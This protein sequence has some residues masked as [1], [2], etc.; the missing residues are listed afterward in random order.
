MGDSGPS[1][2]TVKR[3]A[4][5]FKTGHLGVDNEKPS[6]RSVSA[7]VPANVKAIHDMI[8]EECRISAE[9]I[10]TYLGIS[11]EKVGA[12]IH[13]D[14]EMRNLAAKWILKLLTT[15]QKR[16]RVDSLVAVLEHFARNESDFLGKLVTGDETWIYCYDPETKEWRHSGSPRPKKFRVQRS[17]QKQMAT[18]FR[19][20]REFCWWTTSNRV[21]PSIQNITV[22]Y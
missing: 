11:R 17:V 6:G 2:A 21:Q 5:N 13:S 12:I 15:E 8:M 14:L 19:I 9:S 16:K 18:V 1:Y 10:A 7:F 22:L 4:V 3:W 20:R